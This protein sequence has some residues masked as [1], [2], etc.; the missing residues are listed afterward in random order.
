M[1]MLFSRMTGMDNQFDKYK[2]SKIDNMDFGYDYNSLMHYGS[3]TF[4][5]NGK[6]TIRARNRHYLPLGR[7]SGF[8]T[9]DIKKINALYDCKSE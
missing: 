5:K 2:Q 1:M 3:K 6:A 7:R 8:S 9:M 4:S